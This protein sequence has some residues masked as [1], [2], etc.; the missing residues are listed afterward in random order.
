LGG[1]SDSMDG[2]RDLDGSDGEYCFFT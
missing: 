1:I 2:A